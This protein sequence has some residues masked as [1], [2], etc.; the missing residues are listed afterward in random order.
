[1]AFD[2]TQFLVG[3]PV[4]REVTLADG[5]VETL[6]FIKPSAAE[7]R[8]WH[9]AEAAG[10]DEA[11]FGMQR[12]IADSLYDP[13]AKKPVFTGDEYKGLTYEGCNILFPHV[14][15]VAGIGKAKKTSPSAAE[16]GSATS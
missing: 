7:V 12:L 13:E 2:K 1:M 4:A 16:S 6:H 10:G 8:R 15:E 11:F 5:S 3:A 14:V 9:A